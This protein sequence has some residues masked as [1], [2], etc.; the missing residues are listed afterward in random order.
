MNTVRRVGTVIVIQVIQRLSVYIFYGVT[1][2]FA[3][4]DRVK[5]ILVAVLAA[6]AVVVC[7][8]S[9]EHFFPGRGE[10]F[11]LRLEVAVAYHL[12]GVYEIARDKHG[13]GVFIFKDHIKKSVEYF[14][15]SPER[16]LIAAFAPY[17]RLARHP[18]LL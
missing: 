10:L 2:I 16:Y 11:E 6:A 12:S 18:Q 9:D 7:G 13:F 1:L 17:N 5:D 8:G 4:P 3:V 15:R 14:G